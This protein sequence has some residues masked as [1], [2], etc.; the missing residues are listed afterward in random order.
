MI[1]RGA[2]HLIN[3]R[4]EGWKP[5]KDVWLTYGDFREPGRKGD[6]SRPIVFTDWRKWELSSTSP[7]LLIRP[8]D[9]IERIDLRC[10][11]GLRI[12]FVFDQWCD[13][14]SR[15]NDRLQ[16]Y[17]KE[18]IVMSPCFDEDIG[19]IWHKRYG[20]IEM[21]D[22]HWITKFEEAQAACAG[23]GR[24]YAEAQARELEILEAAPWL[25]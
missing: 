24:G 2:E 12:V 16:E 5:S 25:R 22:R 15:L 20:Q 4:M 21:K 8:E 1:P 18:I 6:R 19:W 9:N 14:V 13:K 23:G 7:Q 10:I 3:L 17:A 11:A